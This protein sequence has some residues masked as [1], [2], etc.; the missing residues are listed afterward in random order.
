MS[1]GAGSA[2]PAGV[3]VG[4]L[5]LHADATNAVLAQQQPADRE[6]DVAAG[7]YR[8]AHDLRHVA[9]QRAGHEHWDNR[10]APALRQEP[11]ES[12]LN[13]ACEA[14]VPW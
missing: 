4:N 5:V 7:L 10:F 9:R 12:L 14:I 2:S 13:K 3:R 11:G 8:P 6:D 1:T